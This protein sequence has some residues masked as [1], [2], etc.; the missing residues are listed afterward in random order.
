MCKH[1]Y[2]TLSLKPPL[3]PWKIWQTNP[4][5]QTPNP[6]ELWSF[7]D[8]SAMLTLVGAGSLCKGHHHHPKLGWEPKTPTDACLEQR[9]DCDKLDLHRTGLAGLRHESQ[10]ERECGVIYTWGAHGWEQQYL[11]GDLYWME[12]LALRDTHTAWATVCLLL[13]GFLPSS[14]K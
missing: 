4:K 13:T 8:D 3:F 6:V 11:I 9:W 2:Q 1:L 10:G 12:P 14:P 5:A 7:G